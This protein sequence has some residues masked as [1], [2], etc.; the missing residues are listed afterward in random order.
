MAI[1]RGGNKGQPKTE[2][3]ID[4]TPA[5]PN[6]RPKVI[7][8]TKEEHQ[9]RL[10][11]ERREERERMNRYVKELMKDYLHT[12]EYKAMQAQAMPQDVLDLPRECLYIDGSLLT[13]ERHSALFADGWRW[14]IEI[15]EDGKW[16]QVFTRSKKKRT[17]SVKYKKNGD[18]YRVQ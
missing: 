6:K 17:D 8:E 9:L 14:S 13:V 15:K 3:L 16:T 18:F 2:R 7:E 11:K 1:E 5:Q 4:K 12:P 10:D